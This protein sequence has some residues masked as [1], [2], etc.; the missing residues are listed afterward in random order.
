MLPIPPLD[1]GRVALGLLPK[2]FSIH[3]IKL[4]KYGLF[5]IIGALFIL[6]IIGDQIGIPLKPI[7]WFIQSISSILLKIIAVITGLQ[8]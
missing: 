6:P 4:E 1:G 8:I 3:L 2:Y 5:I 7:H